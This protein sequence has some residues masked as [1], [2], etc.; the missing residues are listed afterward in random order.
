ME[1]I[2]KEE[3]TTQSAKKGGKWV[4]RLVWAS[5]IL[6]LGG[7]LSIYFIVYAVSTDLG[8]LFGGLPGYKSLE[9]PKND[10]SSEIYTA[11]GTL[12]GK[13]YRT[14]RTNVSYEELS[15]NIKKALLDT[16]DD[17]FFEHS[18]ISFKDLI[19]VG[20][21]SVILRQ[22]AGGGSTLSQ[23]L[24]KNLYST[25]G[26]E[27]E[28][29]LV[30]SLGNNKMRR[31][32]DLVIVKIKEWII[33]V[34]LERRFTKEEIFA[35]YLNTVPY[36]SNAFGIQ[37]AAKTFFNKDQKD[38]N[39]QEA[40]TLVGVINAPTRYSPRRHP[41]RSKNKRNMVLGQMYV[42]G[43]LSKAEFDSLKQLPIELQFKV[44]SHNEG[45]ATY[46][47]SAIRPWLMRWAKDND[48]DLWEDGIKI[49]TTID[50]RMQEYAEAALEEHM[51]KLQAKFDKHWEGRNPWIDEK[52]KEIPNFI[53]KQT[54]RL[55][56][57]RSL[58]KKYGK[59]ADSV[60]YY[61][62]LKKPMEVFSWEGEI[63]T[64][65]STVDSLKYYKQFL[66]AGFMAMNP[67][68]G[69]IKAWV[70]GINYEHF[71]YDHVMQGKRQPGSTFKPLVYGTAIENGYS[72]C[73]E[74]RDIPYTF[75]LPKGS[76]KPTWTPQNA[77]GKFTGENMS[78]RQAMAKS[79]N[80]ITA[81]VMDKVGPRQVVD[82]ANRL[83]VAIPESQ[84]V[85]SLALGIAD[86]SVFEMTGAYGTFVNKGVYT[87]PNFVTR[88]E[89]KFGNTI[90]EF[91]AQTKEAISEETAYLM[92]YML[93]GASEE[94][95]GTAVGLSWE[96]K[97]NNEIG[98]KTGTTQNASDGWFMG[99]T[100][101]LVCGTWVGG[102]SRS[103]HFRNWYDGQGAR[104]ARPIFDKFMRDVYNDESLGYTKGAFE[105]PSKPISM[106]LDCD[107]LKSRV[108][109]VK[110]EIVEDG[111]T[112]VI[113][114]TVK[115]ELEDLD[116]DDIF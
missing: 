42:Y 41:E 33:A 104:T 19:R 10:L 105:R 53:E 77:D 107:V 87:T 93:R 8:G 108:Y 103:I 2:E 69:Q 16:E 82:F 18:G 89:D 13:Y 61:I 113:E 44:D 67:H 25:R 96:L 70:G 39:V 30:Q 64:L 116:S 21:K 46:F 28:G 3:K 76:T 60:N 40:A 101:D 54:E 92:V 50:G 6:F 51:Q 111:D 83:G 4:K 26:D 1:E 115:P 81:F 90:Q 48:I 73:Y 114:K 5:W 98:G 102:D 109:K 43:D 38:L 106:E 9:N 56:Y 78:L 95:G 31:G 86:V 74:V 35:M 59:G 37:V 79:V 66:Q 15:P 49:Y 94:A 24:A 55:P 45:L 112:T 68:N 27:F 71:K 32:V 34:Q 75:Q 57:Y 23:Q 85:P 11:D 14:N 84:A 29:S 20:I 22:G 65:M 91:P 88:I 62:N 72:P 47:R 97:E 12:M 110:E 100:K 17:S 7:F 58:V 80:S 63:D 99:V 36:G 52:G